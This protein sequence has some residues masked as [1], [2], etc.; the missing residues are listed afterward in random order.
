MR[1]I[2]LLFIVLLAALFYY[3]KFHSEKKVF[4]IG[5]ECDYAPN[6]WEE[7]RPSA[8]NFPL[9][10][11]EGFYAE[12][13]D[14][15]IAKVVADDLGMTLEVKKIAWR[16]LLPA[17]NRGEIDAVFSGMLDTEERKKLAA[18]S[19][20]YE[21]KKTEYTVIL[22]KQSKYINIKKLEELYGAKML[23][24]KGTNLD[25]A[26]DQIPGAIHM[27]PVDTVPEMLEM[28]V[29]NKVDGIVMNYDTGRSYE[30]T[31]DNLKLIR[32]PEGEGFVLGFDGICAAVRKKDRDLL[33]K[34]N[35]ALDVISIR[36]RQRIMDRTI[37]RVW[38]NL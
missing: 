3:T 18:F 30:R 1:K 20:T 4:R 5:T 21:V 23:A 10:N 34:I 32:F 16:D 19:H 36:E 24:Q 37:S 35:E 33:K 27:P 15:Q 29:S 7:K 31:Y 8:S 25:A 26:I 13:Y 38:E 17:L 6:N 28:L 11:N 9:V 14:I 22:N 12:G 2:I